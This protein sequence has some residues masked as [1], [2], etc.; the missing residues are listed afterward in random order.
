MA[1][2]DAEQ[3]PC[4]TLLENAP[5][6]NPKELKTFNLKSDLANM[7]AVQILCG[8]VLEKALYSLVLKTTQNL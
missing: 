4:G 2:T 3:I 1:T 8:K 6:L 7:V 5:S